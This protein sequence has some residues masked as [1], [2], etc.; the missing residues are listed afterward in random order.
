MP[1]INPDSLCILAFRLSGFKDDMCLSNLIYLHLKC[2]FEGVSAS[3]IGRFSFEINFTSPSKVASLQKQIK[4]LLPKFQQYV[5]YLFYQVQHLYCLRFKRF[6]VFI[7]THSTP[8]TGDLWVQAKPNPSAVTP[9]Q[10][11]LIYIMLIILFISVL[12]FL[13]CLFPSELLEVIHTDN[14]ASLFFT[15][16]NGPFI[17]P[18]PLHQIYAFAKQ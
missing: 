8:D 14:R 4:Q 15:T 1:D 5:F 9:E 7:A 10:V 12:Q 6:L 2:Y 13:E 17:Y 18:E 3:K 11:S 16:C